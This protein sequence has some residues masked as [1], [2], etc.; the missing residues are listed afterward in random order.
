[1]NI[2]DFWF[3]VDIKEPNECWPW[4]RGKISGGYGK[5]TIGK[6]LKLAHRVAYELV[7]GSIPDG[8]TI[9]HVKALGC[10]NKA[11]CNPFHLEIVTQRE[12]TL[13][14]TGPSAN[15]AKATHCIHG[16]TF[17]EQNTHRLPD[18]KR[19]CRTCDRERHHQMR[20]RQHTQ[21][22]RPA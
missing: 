1:M 17:D 14:G 20:L 7:K 19:V 6:V 18:G 13:R 12:N 5:V 16:H 15:N 8:M 21:N 2:A 3:N 4:L 11:C 9:D 22:L 10:N